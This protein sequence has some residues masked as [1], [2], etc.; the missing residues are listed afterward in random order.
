MR[1]ILFAAVISV[2]SAGS[3]VADC[4]SEIAKTKGGAQADAK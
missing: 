2:T 1:T 3:A 4:N